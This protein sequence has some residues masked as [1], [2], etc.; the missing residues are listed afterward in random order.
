MIGEIY[1]LCYVTYCA[2]Q[3][4]EIYPVDNVIH[5]SN[6][7]SLINNFSTH[8]VFWRVCF[9]RFVLFRHRFFFGSTM[10]Q[11][12][13]LQKRPWLPSIVIFEKLKPLAEYTK[14]FGKS[15]SSY[16]HLTLRKI[17]ENVN[18]KIRHLVVLHINEMHVLSYFLWTKRNNPRGFFSGLV[19]IFWQHLWS[20]SWEWL[21]LFS[22]RSFERTV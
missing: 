20:I 12:M 5:L 14:F 22:R 4:I 10:A 13:N 8:A 21:C 9:Y 3:Q 11:I 7:Q 1:A 15:Q 18:E 2:L 19:R 6:N 16:K 17:K